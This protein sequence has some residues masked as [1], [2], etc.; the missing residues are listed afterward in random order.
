MEDDLKIG[1]IAMH[2]TETHEII[3]L[4]LQNRIQST[5][6]MLKSLSITIHPVSIQSFYYLYR[7]KHRKIEFMSP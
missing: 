4:L 7:G 3:S 5:V 6:K 1:C 2:A